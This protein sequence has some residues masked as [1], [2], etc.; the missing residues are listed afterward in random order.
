MAWADAEFEADDAAMVEPNDD[1]EELEFEDANTRRSDARYMTPERN[2]P[3]RRQSGEVDRDDP[4][5]TR[6]LDD[7]NVEMNDDAGGMNL[8]SMQSEVLEISAV[9]QLIIGKALQGLDV[10]EFYSPVRVKAVAAHIGLVAG[11]SLDLTNGYKF[12]DKRDQDKAWE[13]IRKTKPTLVIGSPP[14]T[15][16]SLL[17]E[18]HIAVHGK[19][20]AWMAR[21]EAA[22]QKAVR[23]F[24]FCCKVYRHQMANGRHV[25]H[26][27][28]WSARSWALECVDD[29]GHDER[30]ALVQSHMCRLGM[31]SR[32]GRDP[33]EVDPVKKPTGFMTTS[34]C[35][36][37]ELDRRC[38]IGL[39]HQHVPL[40]EGRAAAAQVYP[41]ELCKAIC[42]GLARQKLYDSSSQCESKLLN[43]RQLSSVIRKFSGSRPVGAWPSLC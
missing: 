40:V 43:V 2:P 22:K 12:D 11:M 20:P 7:E 24:E 4:S 33:D 13:V 3:V 5:K 42:S 17:Q 36:R 10:L 38:H 29:L 26:E 25:L 1:R 35:I 23:H 19:D 9:D 16:F 34:W 21:F 8:D 27:H 15:Y 37:D 32:I 6:R 39:N 30:V 41:V 28:P 18:L 31:T 14:C